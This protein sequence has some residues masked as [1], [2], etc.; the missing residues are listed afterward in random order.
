M[1]LFV[2]EG[3]CIGCKQCSLQAPSTFAMEP[4][5]N[6][7][8]VE[9]QWGDDEENV[10]IAVACCP[11]ECIHT[12]PTEDLAV[13]EW[14]HRSQPRQRVVSVSGDGLG[15]KGKGL[16][17]SPFVAMERFN[18]RRHEMERDAKEAGGG[19]HAHVHVHVSLV[20]SFVT[21]WS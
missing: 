1:A 16:D 15:G 6:V 7:A 12:V 19:T 2:D 13:L 8:R 5:Y 21:V 14:I 3:R 20:H 11:T 4:D 9:T 18:R 10:E 17:E